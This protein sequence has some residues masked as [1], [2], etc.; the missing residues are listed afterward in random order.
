MEVSGDADESQ[1]IILNLL[2]PEKQ[3]EEDND[4]EHA[5]N[6]GSMGAQADN[7]FLPLSGGDD[8]E[9]WDPDQYIGTAEVDPNRPSA[10][11]LIYLCALCS[12]LTSV[13]LGYGEQRDRNRAGGGLGA[14][15]RGWWRVT[16]NN[17]GRA[18]L[19]SGCICS[20]APF[21]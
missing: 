10:R 12:S 15:G 21:A 20:I 17:E 2:H 14:R 19:L 5:N 18:R 6:Y 8:V 7:Q 1:K 13:L 16:F 11:T 4:V 3:L 9:L